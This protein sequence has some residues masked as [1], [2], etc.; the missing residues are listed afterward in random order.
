MRNYFAGS[1][2][3]LIELVHVKGRLPAL[4]LFDPVAVAIVDEGGGAAARSYGRGLILHIPGEGLPIPVRHVSI[5]I[6]GVVLRAYRS[7]RMG[8]AAVG[9]VY[10]IHHG[11]VADRVVAPA[12]GVRAGGGDEPVQE[13]VTEGF[14]F[15]C[16]NVLPLAEVP[17]R[18]PGVSDVLEG[19]AAA[20]G[21]DLP[22]P[23]VV[24][25]GGVTRASDVPV[26]EVR[27]SP[28]AQ[29]D[30]GYLAELVICHSGDHVAGHAAGEGV[31]QAA[32]AVGLSD[33]FAGGIG[34]GGQSISRIIGESGDIF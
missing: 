32:S 4:G 11:N 15:G 30:P 24:A 19:V 27:L 12:L 17:A 1:Y 9:I 22:Q 34:D 10:T 5:G 33:D 25:A 28:V 13:V 31:G 18:V 21:V 2:V 29:V 3:A 8:L 23:A 6:V 16:H 20:G 14:G 26:A 7:N